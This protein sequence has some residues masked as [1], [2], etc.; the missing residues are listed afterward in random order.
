MPGISNSVP[1]PGA[2]SQPYGDGALISLLQLA[3]KE[4]YRGL[5]QRYGNQDYTFFLE[6]YGHVETIESQEF[7]WWEEHGK[8]HQGFTV[9]TAV[10]APAANATVTVVLTA[11]SHWSSG[12]KSPIYEGVSVRIVSSGIEGVI[13]TVNKGTA[14]AHSCTI[15]PKKAGSAFVSAG[16]ANLLANEVIEIKGNVDAGERSDKLDSTLEILDKYSNTTTEIRADLEITDRAAM[17]KVWPNL[18][19]GAVSIG[20]LRPYTHYNLFK[21]EKRFLNDTDFKL[22]FGDVQT[23]TAMYTNSVGSQGV[24]PV[25]R[26]RGNTSTYTGGALNLA[27]IQEINRGNDVEGTAAYIH[28]LMDIFQSDDFDNTLFGELGGNANAPFV[29]GGGASSEQASINYGFGSIRVGDYFY[30]KKKMPMFNAEVRT[31]LVPTTDEF[32]NFGV[33]I[34]QGTT[35]DAKDPKKV[36]ANLTIMRETPVGGGVRNGIKVWEWGANADRPQGSL[37]THGISMQSFKAT[38]L[39]GANQFRIVRAV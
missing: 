15:R 26:A 3:E 36:Y 22:L 16:S 5:V 9:Q 12:A 1:Q 11:G 2:I 33:Q 10:T 39:A 28:W 24:I 21:T 23:N 13:M 19:A 32:R 18:P 14:G 7:E 6:T 37:A 17:Q 35:R 20:G 8:L 4:T 25:I 30:Q 34:P 29:Y 38:R 31:G 27:K